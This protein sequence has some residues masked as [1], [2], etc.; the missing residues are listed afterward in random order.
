LSW[1]N[2]TVQSTVNGHQD[3]DTRTSSRELAA[4]VMQGVQ[5]LVNLEIALAKQELK[6]IAIHNLIAL[7]CMAAAALLA[8]TVVLV[9]VPVLIVEVVPWHWQ[10]AA[11]WALAYGLIAGGLALYGKSRLSLRLPSRTIESLK[12]NKEWAL[13]QLRSTKR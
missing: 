2:Q 10:A 7:A 13:H 6:E 1:C 3:P 8:I 12:E 4:D 11:V 9:A 5:R